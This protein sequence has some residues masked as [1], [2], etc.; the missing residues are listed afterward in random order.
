MHF[1]C[2]SAACECYAVLESWAIKLLVLPVP[3][4]QP[5]CTCQSVVGDPERHVIAGE[6]PQD[7]GGHSAEEV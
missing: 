5:D 2:P 4:L 3:G 1:C 7:T 6:S